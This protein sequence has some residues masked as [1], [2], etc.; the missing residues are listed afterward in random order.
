MP[1]IVATRNRHDYI[2][3]LYIY[4]QTNIYESLIGELQGQG[5]EHRSGQVRILRG[6]ADV[7]YIFMYTQTE[8]EKAIMRQVSRLS[9]DGRSNMPI[10]FNS[11]RSDR[12]FLAPDPDLDRTLFAFRFFPSFPPKTRRK[13][14]DLM[15]TRM[16]IVP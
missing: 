11:I 9:K 14:I 13:A 15:Y 5:P 2:L 6:G 1:V 3:S 16:S 4:I 8:K 7:A 12:P 10:Q